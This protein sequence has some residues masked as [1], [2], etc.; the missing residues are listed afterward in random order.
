MEQFNKASN[1]KIEFTVNKENL[2]LKDFKN[3]HPSFVVLNSKF[4]LN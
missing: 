3:I 4:N 1:T 2:Q